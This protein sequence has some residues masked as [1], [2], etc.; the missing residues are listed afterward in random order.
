MGQYNPPQ[1]RE[2]LIT[3]CFLWIFRPIGR[4]VGWI[5]PPYNKAL[6]LCGGLET[7]PTIFSGCLK[8]FV[9]YGGQECPPYA[10]LISIS[11]QSQSGRHPK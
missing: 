11:T 4:M 1:R 7:H 6:R 9:R 8:G 3:H 10:K 5:V 2:K